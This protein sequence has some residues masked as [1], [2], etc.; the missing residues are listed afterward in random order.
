MNTPIDFCAMATVTNHCDADYLT[1]LARLPSH[2]TRWRLP[3]AGVT[4]YNRTLGALCRDLLG[5]A[6]A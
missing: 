1:D 3:N 4:A 2:A 5:R 6:A